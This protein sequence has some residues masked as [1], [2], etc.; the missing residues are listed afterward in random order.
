M[1][2]LLRPLSDMSRQDD[3][4]PI[5]DRC[6][7]PL[8]WVSGFSLLINLLMLTSSLYMMQVYDRVLSSG[9][10]P[11]LLYLTLVAV[12]AI[13]LM[14]AL[15]HARGRM[16]GTLGDW[17][18][19][20]LGPAVLNRMVDG[21]LLGEGDRTEPL[22]DLGT[23]RAV[24]GGGLLFLFDAPWVPVYLG[25]IYLL[26]PLLGHV[27]TASALLLFALALA[28][29]RIIR[30][31]LREAKSAGNRAMATAEAALR[32]AEAVDAMN[33]LPGLTR[34]WR[35]DHARSLD[36]QDRAQGRGAALLG[37]T[38]FLRQTVQVA[39]LGTGAWL[40]VRHEMG[41]G[42]MMA[43]SLVVG[44]ALAPV[45]QA[46]GGWRQVSAGREALRRLKAFLA[47]MPRR[48][49]GLPLPAPTGHLAVQ[50]VAFRVGTQERLILNGVSFE[51]RPG[52]AL[53]VVGPSAAGK[54]TLARLLVGLYPPLAGTVRLDGA[55]LFQLPRDDVGR[56][57][58]YLP[59]EIGLF[60]GTVAENIARL[61]T[62]DPDSVVEAARLADCHAM[63]LS[64]PKGYDTEIGGGGAFL[65]GG[66]RQRIA[67]ARAL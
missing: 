64:L 2:K 56:H 47:R 27:A 21:A 6:W 25:L 12:G 44:R 66:Q 65:S 46:I 19:R 45:E 29:D 20:R 13:M 50:G 23:V 37:V 38:K 35:H 59:Q 31:S 8:L 17:L 7:T 10:L 67:L 11:T 62:P 51:A 4:E 3:I 30:A 54:S 58:G 57:I 40:V 55:D 61:D 24:L 48:P 42:S 33:L 22:R 5:F 9:S 16:L 63:I 28:T 18:E 34:R 53:A 15:D 43:A 32:N 39:M 14:S 1:A 26:H 41:A 52:E 49:S 60:A 36:S